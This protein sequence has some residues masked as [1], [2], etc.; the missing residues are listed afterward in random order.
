LFLIYDL[1][2]A[3]NLAIKT[4]IISLGQGNPLF[5]YCFSVKTANKL[6]FL[7]RMSNKQNKSQEEIVNNLR[8]R[9]KLEDYGVLN[10]RICQNNNLS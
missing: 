2:F 9:I 1:I 10:V 3:H 5:K 8:T 4:R 7:F 6:F